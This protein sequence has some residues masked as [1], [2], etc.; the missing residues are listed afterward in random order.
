[1]SPNGLLGVGSSSRKL[2]GD[3]QEREA[4]RLVCRPRRCVT[5]VPAGLDDGDIH[6]TT[7]HVLNCDLRELELMP[8]R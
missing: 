7:P 8:R 1:M 5:G 2:P 6:A 4:R 3:G